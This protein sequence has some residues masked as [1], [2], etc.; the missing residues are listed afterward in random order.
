MGRLE[1]KAAIVTGAGQGIGRGIALIMAREDAHVAIVDINPDTAAS[2]AKEIEMRGG[3]A[4]AIRCDVGIRAQA[5]A[6]IAAAAKA[7]GRLD[8]LVNDAQR[9]IG[10]I[11]LEDMTDE[12][13]QQ[14]FQ[15]GFLGTFYFMQGCFPYMRANG[16]KIVNVGS[17]AGT[18]GMARW[19]A[20]SATKEAIR[21]ITR[22]AAKEWGKYNI[23]VNAICPASMTPAIESWMK[24]D[25]DTFKASLARMPLGRY[26]D[27]EKDIA[28]VVLALVSSDFNYV[29][30]QTIMVDGGAAVLR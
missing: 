14:S 25:P 6:A 10:E 2:T 15:S 16:G 19:G 17:A 23:N 27:P 29:T 8:I 30:G 24:V 9:I 11:N 1:G 5:D 21:A 13:I 3:S 4:V 18:E 26:G 7:F 20:Y 28:P 12:V 22:V